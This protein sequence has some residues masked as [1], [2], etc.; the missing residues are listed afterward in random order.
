MTRPNTEWCSMMA[1]SYFIRQRYVTGK[2]GMIRRRSICLLTKRQPGY[3]CR[4]PMDQVEEEDE[5][6]VL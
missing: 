1:C 4:C 5:R 2:S 3:M 6:R